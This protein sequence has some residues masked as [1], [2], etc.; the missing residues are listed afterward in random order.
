M[1]GGIVGVVLILQR[2]GRGSVGA[3]HDRPLGWHI[4]RVAH[5]VVLAHRGHG[6]SAVG[7][8][9]SEGEGRIGG[10]AQTRVERHIEG[11]IVVGVVLCVVASLLATLL[12][13]HTER[14]LVVGPVLPD[15]H[16]L[17]EPLGVLNAVVAIG[18]VVVTYLRH[19][20]VGV[21]GDAVAVI[22]VDAHVVGLEVFADHGIPV[23]TSHLAHTDGHGCTAN[24]LQSELVVVVLCWSRVGLLQFGLAKRGISA[25]GAAGPCMH[26]HALCAD[27]VAVIVV[28]VFLHLGELEDARR[29][30]VSR[31]NLD[32]AAHGHVVEPV[33]VIGGFACCIDGLLQVGEGVDGAA[34]HVG[35]EEVE[36]A[37]TVVV[38]LVA[39]V[40]LLALEAVAADVARADDAH[41]VGSGRAISLQ[42]ASV[43]VERILRE[44]ADAVVAGLH[45]DEV[46]RFEAQRQTA[47]TRG[48]GT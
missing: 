12:H 47:L 22:A 36:P 20:V 33:A 25:L 11:T 4:L 21:A 24:V 2:D 45:V 13:L 42:V 35:L 18:G 9:G 37:A 43:G 5:A 38:V 34:L 8:R 32:V 16:R 46:G 40:S 26:I 44:G 48:G 14:H 3:Q 15:A 17:E 6:Q 19:L 30:E 1:L 27:G 31:Q 10:V 7:G 41:I 29:V 28:G 39:R 23:R